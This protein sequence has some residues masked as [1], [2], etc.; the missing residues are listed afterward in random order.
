MAT[1]LVLGEVRE[2]SNVSPELLL[3]WKLWDEQIDRM[4]IEIAKR[5]P[6]SRTAAIL[7]RSPAVRHTA[8]RLGL[9]DSSG[10]GSRGPAV[11]RTTG[12]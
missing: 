1:S 7:R 5:Q 8:A 9:P 12:V 6:Q 11:W 10:G 2:L 4:E 3:G